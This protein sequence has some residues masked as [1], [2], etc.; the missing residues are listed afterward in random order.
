MPT[1]TAPVDSLIRAN[2]APAID[3]RTLTGYPIVFDNWTTINSWEG[4]FKER[5]APTAL[6]RTLRNNGKNV[7]V[8]FNHGMDPSIGDKPL[9]KPAVM[10]TDQKG[11]YVEVPLSDTSYNDDLLA[12]MRDGA[13]DG[14]S[15][16]FSVVK[17]DW[18][19]TDTKMPERTITELKLYEFGPVTFPAY[20]ATTVG[21][22]SR[23]DFTQWLGLDDERRTKIAHIMG[24]TL[25][26]E[27]A[28]GTPSDRLA[29]EATPDPQGA[30]SGVL[31]LRRRAQNVAEPLRRLL[32]GTP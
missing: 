14:Q 1:F 3:G 15:F 13:I 27:L 31:I 16:R 29:T 32:N 5:I 10:Q 18:Q 24:R 28:Y 25:S 11:L 19:K 2:P 8:L 21:I 9:G 12:L 17:E 4:T 7:K 22:R 26:D 30:H 6:E 23:E 20:Q